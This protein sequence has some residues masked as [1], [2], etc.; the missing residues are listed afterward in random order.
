M[1]DDNILKLVKYFI[2]SNTAHCELENPFLRDLMPFQ[3]PCT[4]TFSETI[5]K[6]V[7][8]MVRDVI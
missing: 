8:E 7:L 3:V 6:K 2:S 4:E 5:I 1:I